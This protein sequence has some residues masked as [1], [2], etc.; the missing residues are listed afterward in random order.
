[1]AY[2]AEI[3]DDNLVLRVLVVPDEHEARGDAFLRDDLGLG[4]VWVQ[5]SYSGKAGRRFA[6][7]GMRWDAGRGTFVLPQPYASWILDAAGDWQ[8]PIP[9]PDAGDWDWDEAAGAW[10]AA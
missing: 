6:G 1:M 10:R 2:F 9:R 7:P 5:T 8:P 4:G 3:N